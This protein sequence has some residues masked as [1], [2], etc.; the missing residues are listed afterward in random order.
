MILSVP[1]L[2]PICETYSALQPGQPSCYTEW[3]HSS[4]TKIK[5][6]RTTYQPH[7]KYELISRV[8]KIDDMA[9]TYLV[10]QQLRQFDDFPEVP[11]YYGFFQPLTT[12]YK[13][14]MFTGGRFKHIISNSMSLN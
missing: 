10:V 5:N 8:R 1:L 7:E 9:K 6:I 11:K 3:L 12:T 13:Q 4:D 2:R 14:S